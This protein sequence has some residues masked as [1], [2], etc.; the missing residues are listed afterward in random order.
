MQAIVRRL[1]GC[2]TAL[3]LLTACASGATQRQQTTSTTTPATLSSSVQPVAGPVMVTIDNT[4]AGGVC[5]QGTNCWQPTQ[6]GPLLIDGE[7]VSLEE[8]TVPGSGKVT[9]PGWPN[10]KDAVEVLCVSTDPERGIYRDAA[11]TQVKD[12][13]GIRVPTDKLEPAAANNPRLRTAPDG[14][15]YLAFVAT[16]WLKGADDLQTSACPIG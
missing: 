13:H 5:A 1:I 14:N 9:R 2:A 4:A 15:G 6:F 8:Q 11:G 3:A 12:W 7:S 10:N 16:M